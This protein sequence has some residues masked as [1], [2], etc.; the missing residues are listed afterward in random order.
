MVDFST[1]PMGE[2]EERAKT[3]APNLML[4]HAAYTLSLE[5]SSIAGNVVTWKELGQLNPEALITLKAIDLI[6]AD[7]EISC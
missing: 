6:Q 5:I 4:M 7:R 2:A 3:F 1:T